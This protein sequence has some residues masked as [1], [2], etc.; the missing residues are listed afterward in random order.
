MSERRAFTLIEL[1]VVIAIIAILAA[2]LFPVFA[3]AREGARKSSCL[4][5]L[6]Q[7][8]KGVIMYTQ[9]Y[10]ETFPMVYGGYAGIARSSEYLLVYPYVKNVDVWRCPSAAPSDGGTWPDSI[11]DVLGVPRSGGRKFNYG[12]N[13]GVLIYAGGGLLEAEAVTPWGQSY[14]AG[15]S[16]AA[17]KAPADV[18]VYSDSYDTYRPT[19]GTDSILDSYTGAPRTSAL[20]HG[21]RFNIAFADGHAKNMQWMGFSIGNDY[22]AVPAN[23][24]DRA[25]WCADPDANLNLSRYG[26]PNQPCGTLLTNANIRA[27]GGVFWP[28]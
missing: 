19:M 21:G 1:L 17:L 12:Y 5:N 10:D 26:L 4:S 14:Q 24:P 25:K 16:L 23:E 15:K 28:N 18:F 27:L 2:I 8:G 9:D 20:R 22:Y 3:Q 13:W 6:N 7:L 11:A